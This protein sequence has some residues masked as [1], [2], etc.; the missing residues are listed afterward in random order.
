M[1]KGNLSEAAKMIA[2]LSKNV[3]GNA[4]VHTGLNVAS[5]PITKI[6]SP[7]LTKVGQKLT[8]VPSSFKSGNG[9]SY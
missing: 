6:N 3:V 5:S 7:L 8:V 2:N 4:Q 1:K 9:K